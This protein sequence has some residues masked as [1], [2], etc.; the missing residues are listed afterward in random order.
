VP[1]KPLPPEPRMRELFAV[2]SRQLRRMSAIVGDVLGAVQADSGAIVLRLERC[3]AEQ[4]AHECI[5]IFE[6][7]APGYR[8]ELDV[9]G[10]TH[11]RADP[12]RFEQVLNNLLSNAVK[13]SP[14]G[15]RVKLE[16][17]GEDDSLV[18]SVTDEGPGIPPDLR[19]QLFRPFSRGKTGHEEIPGVGLGLYVSRRIVEAHGGS[20]DVRSVLGEG[21]TFTL[22]LPRGVEPA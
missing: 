5:E 12:R 22:K 16:I 6:T 18:V 20:I 8:F 3:D 11:L 2:I 21:S 15:S 9:K 14:S 19:D 13:Y 4:L 10:P 1:G 17:S 7:M